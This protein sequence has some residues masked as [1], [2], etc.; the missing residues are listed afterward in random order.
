MGSSRT[1]SRGCP[2]SA[3][4]SAIRCRWP[5]GEDEAAVAEMG[6]VAPRQPADQ[7]VHAGGPGGGHDVGRVGVAEAGDVLPHR[8]VEQAR[9]LRQVAQRAAEAGRLVPEAPA[10]RAGC[11]PSSAPEADKAAAP[12]STCR[13][14]TGR[15]RRGP[16]RPRRRSSRCAGPGVRHR[17]GR[18]RRGR[19]PA[20][21]PAAIGIG[22]L[23]R[24]SASFAAMI[25]SRRRQAA[26]AP[27]H[28]RQPSISCSNG[29]STRPRRIAAAQMVP[30]VT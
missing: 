3:R 24:G 6:L 14:R 2:N 29:N 18:S 5:P 21:A 12:A 22:A 30:P 26:R 4:A 25:P 9:V 28:C 23:E 16:R 7:L 20:P 10:R 17:P 13:R 15:S 19:R 1:S 27:T 11:R 8:A